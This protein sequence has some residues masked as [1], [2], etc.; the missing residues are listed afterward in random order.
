MDRTLL[1]RVRTVYGTPA[2][3]PANETAQAFCRISGTKTLTHPVLEEAERLGFTVTL[4]REP[5]PE[6][7]SRWNRGAVPPVTNLFNSNSG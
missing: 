1:V 5:L 2:M 4:E 7:L 6:T 3:Y